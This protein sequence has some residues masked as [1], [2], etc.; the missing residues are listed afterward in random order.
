MFSTLK[1]IAWPC[2]SGLLSTFNFARHFIPSLAVGV[3]VIHGKVVYL[4]NTEFLG[5]LPFFFV[6]QNI[7]Y[8]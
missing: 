5:W 7:P 4:L 1:H 8:H 3:F 6:S 2:S